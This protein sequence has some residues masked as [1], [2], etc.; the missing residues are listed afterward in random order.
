M[1]KY[2]P[3]KAKCYYQQQV[4]VSS[5]ILIPICSYSRK[6]KCRWTVCEQYV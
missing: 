2:D 5:L 6:F 3:A 4:P 1:K